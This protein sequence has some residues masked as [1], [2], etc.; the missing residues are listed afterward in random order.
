MLKLDHMFVFIRPALS[1]AQ[2]FAAG[3]EHQRHDGQAGR[4]ENE[5]ADVAQVLTDL[6]TGQRQR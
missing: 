3:K 1:V 5:C 2:E 4:T 6:R